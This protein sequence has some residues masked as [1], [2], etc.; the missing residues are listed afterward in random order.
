MDNLWTIYGQFMDNF[1]LYNIEH[2][3]KNLAQETSV[4]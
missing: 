4:I 2:S 1:R 3:C